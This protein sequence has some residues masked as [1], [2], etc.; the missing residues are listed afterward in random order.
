MSIKTDDG[1]K[2]LLE[3]VEQ[4][5]VACSTVSDGHMLVFKRSKLKELLE[6]NPNQD[7]L[8]IFVKR[9]DFKG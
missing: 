7:V 9:P 2:F 6:Q 4:F 8:A 1:V 3:S 5:G